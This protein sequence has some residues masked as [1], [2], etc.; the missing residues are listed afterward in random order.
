MH[1]EIRSFCGSV[2]HSLTCSVLHNTMC[3]TTPFSPACEPEVRPLSPSTL[4]TCSP[5]STLPEACLDPPRVSGSGFLLGHG[6][7]SRPKHL[8]WI[9]RTLSPH[10]SG[11]LSSRFLVPKPSFIWIVFEHAKSCLATQ[12]RQSRK[13]NDVRRSRKAL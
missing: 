4:K 10:N 6:I 11:M 1:S 7:S 5:R 2:R 9:K 13:P 8:N 3:K 12:L